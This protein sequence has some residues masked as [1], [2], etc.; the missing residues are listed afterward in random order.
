MA[1]K[2][3]RDEKP[4]PGRGLPGTRSVSRTVQVL[5]TVAARKDIGWRLTDLASHCSLDNAT[6]YRIL[7]CLTAEGMVQQRKHDRRYVPGPLLFELALSLPAYSTFQSAVHPDLVRIAKTLN[8]IAFLFLRSGQESVCIDRAGSSSVNP[9]TEI[10]TRHL[11]AEST[12]GIAMLLALPK[13]EQ[14]SLI[15]ATLHHGHRTTSH[16]RASYI[17]I[18]QRSRR[19]GYGVNRGDLVPGL[20]TVA[21][22]IMD[23]TGIPFAALALMGPASLF[24]GKRLEA[25]ARHLKEAADRISQEQAHLIISFKRHTMAPDQAAAKAGRPV[26]T[27]PQ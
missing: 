3:T 23:P 1:S 17:K 14:Q 7:N 16:R 5:K 2:M 15:D 21:I 6:A 12:A 18:L 8:G 11:R 27:M 22:P 10:G 24:V 20:P 9:L 25:I 19:Y 4:A 13:K 26:R